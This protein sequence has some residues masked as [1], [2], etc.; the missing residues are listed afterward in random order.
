M[1]DIRESLADQYDADLLFLDPG[2][3][4]DSCIV[5]VASRCGLEHC[6]VYDADQIVKALVRDGMSDEEALE[7]MD[8]N[9]TGA[10]VGERTP[11]FIN[12]IPKD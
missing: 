9:I 1:S 5:G 4:F 11:L 7:Y 2:W 12:L 8:F 6:V 3:Q 10:Y